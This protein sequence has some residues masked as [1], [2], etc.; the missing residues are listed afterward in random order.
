MQKK[1]ELLGMPSREVKAWVIEQGLPAFTA[2]Q[3]L[4]WIYNKH[5]RSF[6]QMTNLSKTT[7]ILLEERATVYQA[8]PVQ[9]IHS[10]DGTIKYLFPTL[11]GDC[12]EAVFIPENDRATLCV[13]SQAGCNRTHG[14]LIQPGRLRNSKSGT[15]HSRC[16]RAD[17]RGVY[18]Y[19]RA[20]GQFG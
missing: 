1:T 14:L 13:S 3:L 9:A 7:R 10:T 6:E 4:D 20:H 2:S 15:L 18:G 19:G 12:V 5:V 16:G 8:E 11:N 17:K